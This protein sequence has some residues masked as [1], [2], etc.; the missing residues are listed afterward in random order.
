MRDSPDSHAL[1][2]PATLAGFTVRVAIALGSFALLFLFWEIRHA[3]ALFFAAIVAATVIDALSQP[4]DRV[5]KWPRGVTVALVLIVTFSGLGAALWLTSPSLDKQL[6]DLNKSFP[7][8]IEKVSQ[9]ITGS[10]ENGSAQLTEI[11]GEVVQYTSLVVSGFTAFI[12]VVITGAFLA[13]A[14]RT[15]SEGALRLFPPH[16]REVLREALNCAGQGLKAWLKGKALSMAVVAVATGLGTWWIGLPAPLLL[17]LLAGLTEFV[18]V[19]GPIIAAVPALLLA[20]TQG[21][22]AILWT[23]GLY[24][25]VQQIESNVILPMI[26]EQ[27]AHLPPGVLMFAFAAMGLVFGVIGIIIAAPFALVVYLLVKE[28]WVKPI[29]ADAA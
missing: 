9:W 1:R 27:V 12:L 6:D 21:T 20:I 10:M 29:E 16:R 8:G 17:G 13:V 25:L 19:V 23:A 28:L 3:L 15:Y 18:P 26:H 22:S 5:A 2:D 14:P 24:V 7:A 11:A 4:I